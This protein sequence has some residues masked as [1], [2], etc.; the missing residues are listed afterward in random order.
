M[1]EV[2]N[3]STVNCINLI[4]ELGDVSLGLLAAFIKNCQLL[5][6]NDT[7]VS[8]IASA[9]RV[10]SVIIFSPYSDIQR[11]APLN[12][13]LHK[14]VSPL[15]SKNAEHVIATAFRQIENNK[16]NVTSAFQ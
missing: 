16:E 5:I 2:E 8:H 4:D 12:R 10:P 3:L 13:N 14:A 7:G 9:G 11:W 1:K 15:E 6:S